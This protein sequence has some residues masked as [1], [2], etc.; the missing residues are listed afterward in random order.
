MF[1]PIKFENHVYDWEIGLDESDGSIRETQG[2]VHL[3]DGAAWSGTTAGCM[4]AEDLRKLAAACNTLADYI[5]ANP[6]DAKWTAKKA[7]EEAWMAI[8]EW[9]RDQALDEQRQAQLKRQELASFDVRARAREL[10]KG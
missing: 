4:S 6:I 8:P 7:D 1:E 2:Q 5:D 9:A 3:F 10:A